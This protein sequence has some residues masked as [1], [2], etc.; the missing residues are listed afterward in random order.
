MRGLL[1]HIHDD[2][3][4]GDSAFSVGIQL[5]D[6]CALLISRHL[7]GYGDSEELYQRIEKLVFKGIVEPN[8][9]DAL[10]MW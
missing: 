1:A 2:M 4:F 7:A 6:M 8:D 3:Y 9:I 5:A 10:P